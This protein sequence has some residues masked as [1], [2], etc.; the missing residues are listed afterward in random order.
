MPAVVPNSVEF[1]IDMEQFGGE[2]EG[3]LPKVAAFLLW[4]RII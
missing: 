1:R 3:L 2:V 4:V